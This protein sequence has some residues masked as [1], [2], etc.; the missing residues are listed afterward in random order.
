MGDYLDHYLKKR[1]IVI[2]WCFWKIY[3]LVLKILQA[4]SISLFQFY[5][6]EL[7]YDVK[8][9]WCKIRK[10][11]RHWHVLIHWKRIKGR[12]FLHSKR[13]AKASKSTWKIMIL[14]NRQKSYRTCI[15]ITYTARE[16]VNISVM[17]DLSG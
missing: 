1:C 13:Y 16:R 14:Q 10:S 5:W 17:V 4:R 15:W 7:G 2:S 8:N 12:N 6:T 9:D 11:F 3:W